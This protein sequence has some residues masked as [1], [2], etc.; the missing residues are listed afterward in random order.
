MTEKEKCFI[1]GMLWGYGSVG[2]APRSQRGGHEFESRYLHQEKRTAF[3]VLS[4]FVEQPDELVYS[5]EFARSDKKQ[6]VVKNDKNGC[7]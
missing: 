5:H 1:I 3:A 4:L 7:R 2:R 6:K